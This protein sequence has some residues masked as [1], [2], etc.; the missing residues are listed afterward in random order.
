MTPLHGI[1]YRNE[2]LDDLN[3]LQRVCVSCREFANLPANAS[4]SLDNYQ[5]ASHTMPQ[6]VE[7]RM[8]I[9]ILFNF[10]RRLLKDSKFVSDTRD[11]LT[12]LVA[13]LL[14]YRRASIYFYFSRP[15][16][17]SSKMRFYFIKNK[18]KWYTSKF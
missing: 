9:T 8:C 2:F 16:N 17:T 11:W 3:F 14:R 1:F 12:K 18:L 13:V 7:L 4:V 10:Q 5:A 6:L 15:C